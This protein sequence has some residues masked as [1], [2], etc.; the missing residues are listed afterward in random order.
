MLGAPREKLDLL[1]CDE[2]CQ[3]IDFSFGVA[4]VALEPREVKELGS[5]VDFLPKSL[6]HS[7]FGLPEVLVELVVV[8]MGQ[9]AHDI[10]HTVVVEETEELKGLHFKANGRVNQQQSQVYNLRHIDHGLHVGGT[11]HKCDSLVLVRT[12]C[13]GPSHRVDFLLGKVV[14]K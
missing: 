4:S 5:I 3:V 1:D 2:S 10:W 9:D 11:L 7:L 12:Q 13:D 6:L 8:Q 14:D